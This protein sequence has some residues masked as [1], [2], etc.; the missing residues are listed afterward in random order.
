V[1]GPRL[2]GAKKI[3][4]S[5]LTQDATENSSRIKTAAAIRAI[6]P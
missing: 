5:P 3:P 2:T 6:I 1:T 4:E